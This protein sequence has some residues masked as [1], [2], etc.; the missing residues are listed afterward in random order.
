MRFI[1]EHLAERISVADMAATIH[2]HPTYF[3]NVFSRT[4]GVGPKRY[5]LLRRV[6]TAQVHLLHSDLSVKEIA[7]ATGFPDAAYLSRVFRS[8][9]GFAPI[10]YRRRGII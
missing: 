1:D 10:E 7:H 9:T 5:L 4:F 6:E 8:I 2:L 3:A